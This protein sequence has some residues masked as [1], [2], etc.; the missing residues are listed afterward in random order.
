LF[1]FFFANDEKVIPMLKV[2]GKQAKKEQERQKE[3]VD[4]TKR[5]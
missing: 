2:K 3:N 4:N 5:K 1:R